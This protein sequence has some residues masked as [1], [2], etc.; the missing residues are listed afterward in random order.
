MPDILSNPAQ[1]DPVLEL[2]FTII[3]RIP[4]ASLLDQIHHF[5]DLISSLAVLF[6]LFTCI[7]RFPAHWLFG[8]A[9]ACLLWAEVWRCDFDEIWEVTR[10]TSGQKLREPAMLKLTL[11]STF[12][13]DRGPDGGHVASLAPWVRVIDNDAGQSTSNR[14][15][16]WGRNDLYFLSPWVLATVTA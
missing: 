12:V 14:H 15:G 8:F 3:W 1:E 13:A 4:T 2:L 16:T 11:P 7:W 9:H 10:F 6:G 5:L